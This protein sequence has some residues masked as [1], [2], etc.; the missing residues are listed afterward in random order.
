M[1]KENENLKK[2]IEITEEEKE[3]E[4]KRRKKE[5][6]LKRLNELKQKKREEE[7]KKKE[8]KEKKKQEE[9]SLLHQKTRRKREEEK[10]K[11][12]K[13][14]EIKKKKEEE[15]KNK[16][17]L[18]SSDN[19]EDEK[20]PERLLK[21]GKK[22]KKFL[23]NHFRTI[24]E[25]LKSQRDEQINSLLW[26]LK[27][28]SP[29]NI[30]GMAS[31]NDWAKYEADA[32]NIIDEISNQFQVEVNKRFRQYYRRFSPFMTRFLTV[33]GEIQPPTLPP[34]KQEEE[35]ARD[36]FLSNIFRKKEK[37]PFK[38][39]EPDEEE[40]IEDEEPNEDEKILKKMLM[41]GSEGS[42]EEEDEK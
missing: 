18:P 20:H 35:V 2:E 16:V 36:F 41:E 34:F 6:K 28:S 7:K 12:E 19:E 37:I 38:E 21:R 39:E 14:E 42:G 29:V 15:R 4:E 13:K 27:R 10:E 11:K 32:K 30:P 24:K 26:Q 23:F 3:K 5:E 33:L 9:L 40:E 25:K 1:E 17:I 31:A 22:N 8:K